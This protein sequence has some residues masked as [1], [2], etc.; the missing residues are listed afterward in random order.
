MALL[1]ISKI[2]SLR[3]IWTRV[4]A[5]QLCEYILGKQDIGI[6]VP[7]LLSRAE[8]IIASRFPYDCIKNDEIEYLPLMLEHHNPKE[9][10]ATIRKYSR[11]RSSIFGIITVP[12]M[13]REGSVIDSS[14]LRTSLLGFPSTQAIRLD[15][16]S[17][18][19]RGTVSK[20]TFDDRGSIIYIPNHYM[21]DIEMNLDRLERDIEK[22]HLVVFVHGLLGTFIAYPLI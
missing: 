10:S 19:V 9:G 16:D 22:I 2:A 6:P 15:T 21:H 5:A 18:S 7:V 4:R 20:S 14:I 13:S 17:E 8:K 11:T 3:T 12:N 1:P